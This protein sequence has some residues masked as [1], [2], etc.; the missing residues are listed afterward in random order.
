MDEPWSDLDAAGEWLLA[1]AEEFQPDVVHLNGYVHADLPLPSAVHARERVGDGHAHPALRWAAPAAERREKLAGGGA[2]YERNPR[3]SQQRGCA[4]EG[5]E[6]RGSSVASDIPEFKS[7]PVLVV[8]HSCVLS[9]W[10][11]VKGEYA[12]P[13]FA[14][15]GRRVGCGLRHADLIV[16]PTRAMLDMLRENYAFDTPSRVISNCRRPDLFSS[17]EK[18][19]VIFSGGRLWDEAKNTALLERLAPELRWPVHLAGNAGARNSSPASH[20]FFL[21]ALTPDALAREL[22]C[23]SIYAAPA[24]YEPFGLGILEAALA[25]CALVLSDLPSLREN[26]SDAAIFISPDN[27]AAWRDE[28]NRLAQDAPR[29]RHLAAAARQRALQFNPAKTGDAY[30]ATWRELAAP[31]QSAPRLEACLS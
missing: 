21:G 30:L 26:W 20:A 23:A 29:R 24:R 3:I 14:K 19:P 31:A 18:Q 17:A 1:L 12:P 22:A 10:S 6:K 8:A 28:L 2:R 5:R 25:G 16:A 27:E 15:Y 13:R 7:C 9:W 4:P 11:A